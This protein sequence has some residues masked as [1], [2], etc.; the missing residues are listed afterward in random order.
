MHTAIAEAVKDFLNL[1]ATT[2]AV[3]VALNATRHAIPV[4]EIGTNGLQVTVH[5]GNRSRIS[6][7]RVGPGRAYEI[8]VTVGQRVA[9]G[10]NA[11]V[12]P[13]ILIGELIENELVDPDNARMAG[14]VLSVIEGT[15]ATPPFIPEMLQSDKTFFSQIPLTYVVYG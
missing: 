11:T 7:E 14:A 4:T 6:G 12:D 3:G 5:P 1:A 10:E 2:T 8:I 9:D 13:L 15:P